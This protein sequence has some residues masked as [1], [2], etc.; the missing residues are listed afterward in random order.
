MNSTIAPNISSINWVFPVHIFNRVLKCQLLTLCFLNYFLFG[1]NFFITRFY[2]AY[3]VCIQE[4]RSFNFF[5]YFVYNGDQMHVILNGE[6]LEEV[7]C[8]KYLGRKWQ[9]MEDMKGM[10]CTEWMRGI[11]L[12]DPWKVSWAIYYWGYRPRSVYTKE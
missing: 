11:E 3:G 7:D 9:P 4:C 5:L 1:R 2:N 12:G 6:P 10:L 8:F